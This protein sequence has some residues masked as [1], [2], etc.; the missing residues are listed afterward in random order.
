MAGIGIITG[1]EIGKN[2][3]GD[4]DRVLLQVE[5]EESD[6]RTIELVTIS[7][8][9]E[10]PGNGCR[11]V[12]VDVDGDDNYSV[13]VAVTDDLT[14]SVSQGEKEIYSTDSPVTG[15]QAR[16][17]W[18]SGGDVVHNQGSESVVSYSA[19]NTALQQLVTDVNAALATK[20]DGASLP[21]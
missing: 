16:T 3:D 4:N 20:A 15:K 9:D 8:I 6:V 14:P 2:R 17:K 5:F 19:L 12:A 21:R 7:G 11:V 1:V 18:E 13:G 10:N